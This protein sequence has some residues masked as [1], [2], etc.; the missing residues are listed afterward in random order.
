MSER[1]GD[2][3]FETVRLPARL[4]EEVDDLYRE[5]R[6][7]EPASFQE[8]LSLL[9]DLATGR[10]DA[11]TAEHPDG[12]DRTDAWKL[13]GR[14]KAVG[15]RRWSDDVDRGEEWQAAARSFY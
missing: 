3:D 11:G 13:A 4:R 5:R 10:L 1:R 6:G 8:S 7:Y 9:V 14:M 12:P 15:K 2:A